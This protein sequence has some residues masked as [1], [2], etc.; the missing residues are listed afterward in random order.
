M[1]HVPRTTALIALVATAAL[2]VACSDDSDSKR[3]KPKS[4]AAT[5]TT[6]SSSA[7]TLTAVEDVASCIRGTFRFTQMDYAGPVQTQ[8]GPTVIMGGIGGRRIELKPD[9]TFHFT[10]DGS[11]TVRFSL[12][13]Q[14]GNPPTNGTAVLKAQSDGSFVPTAQTANFNITALSGTLVLTL[15]NGQV[16]NIPLP[17]D[18]T[19]VKETFGLN[20]DATYTCQ[21]NTVAFRFPALTI[22]LERA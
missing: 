21:G 13:G 18:G 15:Q 16:V 12:L 10:D 19:G 7:P 11:D 20:G 1:R 6:T 14:A 17:P 5:T 9:N 8:F 4:S 22:T 3:A 2:L